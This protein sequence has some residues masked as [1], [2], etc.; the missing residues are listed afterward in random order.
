VI[1][2]R[3]VERSDLDA[4][5]ALDRQC[6]RP[7]IAYSKSELRYYLSHPCSFSF[8]AEDEAHTILGFAIAESHLEDGIRAGHIITIDIAPAARR[9]GLGRLLM[10]ALLV[11]LHSIGTSIVKLEVA[12]DN[13]G[14]Q[15]FYR[16]LGF[17]ETGRI[18]G[19]YM[20]K[21]DALVMEAQI[22]EAQVQKP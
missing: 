5:F 9:L 20:G 7:G 6:F 11:R 22:M 17:F 10:E 8:V 4:L 15:T 16:K 18:R 3:G 2:L 21:L 13:E 19:F 14:A 1:Q 12:V